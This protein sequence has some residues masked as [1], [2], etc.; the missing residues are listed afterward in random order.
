MRIICR[1]ELDKFISVT[2]TNLQNLMQNFST[3][4]LVCLFYYTVYRCTKF[5]GLKVK[6]NN[7]VGEKFEKFCRSVNVYSLIVNILK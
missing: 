4:L 3:F 1:S 7:Q 6:E 2:I 5:F